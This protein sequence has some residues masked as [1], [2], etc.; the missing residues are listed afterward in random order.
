MTKHDDLPPE[1]PPA[2]KPLVVSC[3]T[4]RLWQVKEGGRD[5]ICRRHPPRPE[6]RDTSKHA[7]ATRLEVVWPSTMPSDWCGEWR[8]LNAGDVRHVVPASPTAP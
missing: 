6:I 2:Q 7:P 3:N 5:G 8:P 1:T 4:C